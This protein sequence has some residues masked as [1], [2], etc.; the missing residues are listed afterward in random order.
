LPNETPYVGAGRAMARGGDFRQ[1]DMGLAWAARREWLER[2]GLFDVGVLGGGDYFGLAAIA[3]LGPPGISPGFDAAY[4][5]YRERARGTRVGFVEGTAF[6][7]HHGDPK[8]RRYGD[9]YDIARRHSF[10]PWADLKEVDG[11]W[12]WA[13][14]KPRFHAEV[15]DYFAGR[16][17]DSRGAQHA[18]FPAGMAR[19]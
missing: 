6:H 3:A 12:V 1:F 16:D 15:A 8:G 11:L 4:L 14:E 10:D 19:Q 18:T 13:S 17:E 5:S 2:V 7:M 9:R